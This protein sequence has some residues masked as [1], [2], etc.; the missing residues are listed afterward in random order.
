[1]KD[2]SVIEQ[3][4][5]LDYCHYRVLLDVFKIDSSPYVKNGVF[6]SSFDFLVDFQKTEKYK[7][8]LLYGMFVLE[9]VQRQVVDPH[10]YGDFLAKVF[11]IIK[12]EEYDSFKFKEYSNFI[13]Q[14]WSWAKWYCFVNLVRIP[15]DERSLKYYL[16][17]EYVTDV[18]QFF[19]GKVEKDKEK[20]VMMK[21][22]YSRKIGFDFSGLRRDLLLQVRFFEMEGYVRCL[23]FGCDLSEFTVK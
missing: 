4:T 10:S 15:I 16:M 7:E 5:G 11:D 18:F 6:I 23:F 14:F 21:L 13:Y 12:V 1:L 17:Y 19:Y 8:V 3:F 20:L 22:L 9:T 2:Y